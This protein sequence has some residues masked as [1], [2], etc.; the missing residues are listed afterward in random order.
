LVGLVSVAFTHGVDVGAV[1]AG[2]VVD[3]DGTALFGR[4]GFRCFIG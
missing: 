3:I 1:Q 2:F 4:V